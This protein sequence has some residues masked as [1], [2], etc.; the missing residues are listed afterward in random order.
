MRII[1]LSEIWQLFSFLGHCSFENSISRAFLQPKGLKDLFP[2]RK[3]DA[4]NAAR[5]TEERARSHNI[6][7][8]EGKCP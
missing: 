6:S 4:I 8:G 2:E 7:T 5:G 3:H 1:L